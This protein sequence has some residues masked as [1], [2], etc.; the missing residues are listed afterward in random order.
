MFAV[1]D[2]DTTFCSEGGGGMGG[3]AALM[4]KCNNSHVLQN[5]II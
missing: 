5:K 2:Q 1:K 3:G 4:N